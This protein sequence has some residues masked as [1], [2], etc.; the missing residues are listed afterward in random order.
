MKLII[1]KAK[2]S[3]EFKEMSADA[4]ATFGDGT[5]QGLNGNTNFPSP[6][7]ALLPATTAGTVSNLIAN[8]RAT[9]QK[10]ASGDKS[11]AL[12]NQEQQ[13]ATALMLALTSN[14]HYVEDHANDL[15]G[16]DVKKA[17]GLI[18]TTGYKLKKKTQLHP[19]D[20][21][22][23]DSGPGW[24]HYRVKKAKKGTEGHIWR[25][26]ITP[27]KGTPPA[28]VIL[29]FTLEADI[30]ITDLASGTIVGIQHTSILPV[31]HTKKTS[32]ATTQTSKT[33]TQIPASKSKHPVYSHTNADPYLWTDFLYTGVM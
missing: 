10:I 5:V 28:T 30:I 3:F 29:R 11:T 2:V 23:V 6:P 18:L 1:R 32:A 27:Q 16:G 22:L 7:I 4:L 14:G 33:A 24:E 26:G 15:G 19:R 8:L 9:L 12:T 25:Y 20:F 13:Q 21:E 31:S 17:E